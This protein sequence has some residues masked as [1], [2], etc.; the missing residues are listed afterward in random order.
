MY[1]CKYEKKLIQE[2]KSYI[3]HTKSNINMWTVWAYLHACIYAYIYVHTY[4]YMHAFPQ[5]RFDHSLKSAYWTKQ[6]LRDVLQ[7]MDGYPFVKAWTLV[8]PL[9]TWNEPWTPGVTPTGWPANVKLNKW[10]SD[11]A[12]VSLRCVVPGGA[13]VR[14]RP[15]RKRPGFES[16]QTR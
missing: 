2:Y 14:F 8:Q 13:I 10:E 11:S 16:R 9:I 12:Q 4:V 15:Q 7:W 6:F 1:I 3:V 5:T